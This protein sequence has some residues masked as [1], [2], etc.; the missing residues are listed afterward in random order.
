MNTFEFLLT[1]ILLIHI[2][3]HVA[4]ES[5]RTGKFTD[6]SDV[7]SYGVMLLELITGRK[8]IM[9]SDPHTHTDQGLVNWVSL[10][11]HIFKQCEHYLVILTKIQRR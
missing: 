1:I 9:D 7:Y 6:K 4:P 3:S 8:P 5:A 2:S 11:I 10:F